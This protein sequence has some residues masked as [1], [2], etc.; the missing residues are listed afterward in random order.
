ML[1]SRRVL[2]EATKILIDG[3]VGD[4]TGITKIKDK[5]PARIQQ[6]LKFVLNVTSWGL[7]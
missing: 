2:L 4:L 6:T 7:Q 5:N 3:K 1:N